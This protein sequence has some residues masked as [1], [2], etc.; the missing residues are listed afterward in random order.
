[1]NIELAS[2]FILVAATL[3][4]IKARTLLPRRELDAEGNEIDPREE[5]VSRLLEYRRYKSVVSDLQSLEYDRRQMQH[6]GN[7]AKEQKQ[8]SE[9]NSVE[10]EMETVSLYKLLKVFQRVMDKYQDRNLRVQHTIIE[11]N[12]TMKERKHYI[13]QLVASGKATFTQVFSNC[14]NRV[15]AMFTFLAVLEMVQLNEI[16]IQVGDGFNNF[17]LLAA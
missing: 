6:R 1:M 15:H 10:A 5:L 13:K 16:G 7:I 8:L 17:W 11:F 12:Y 9:I 4:R 14:D 2:E 3:M